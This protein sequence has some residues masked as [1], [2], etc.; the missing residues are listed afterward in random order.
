[1]TDPIRPKLTIPIKMALGLGWPPEVIVLIAFEL[2]VLFFYTQVLGL[3]GTLTGAALFVAM[4]LDGL[5]DPILGTLS[6]NLRKAPWGR[7][8]TLMFLAPIPM[9]LFFAL[10]F[11]P[12]AFLHGLGLFVWLT[13]TVVACRVSTALFIIPNSAQI[14]EMSRESDVRASLSIYR[15]V[16]QTVFQ[17]ALL[18]LSFKVFFAPSAHFANGQE[19]R[20]NYPLFGMAWGAVLFVI[21]ALSAAGTYRFM[22]AVEDSTPME[23]AKPMSAARFLRSWKVALT[24]NPNVRVVFLGAV[25]MVA[26]SGIARTL[27]SHMAI[28]F[29]E[30]TPGQIAN[31]QLVTIPGMLVGLFLA[32]YLLKFSDMKPLILVSMAAIY[33]SYIL[34]A[35]LKLMGLFPANAP[36]LVD[37]TLLAANLVQGLGFGVIGIVSALM[38]AQTADEEELL[39]GGPEQGLLFG[40]I[41]LGTKLGSGLGKLLSGMALDMIKFPVGKPRAAIGQAVID[42]LALTQIVWVVVLG[43]LSLILWG[44][45]SITNRR[46]AEIKD[47]LALRAAARLAESAAPAQ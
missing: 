28:Y 40:F 24:G 47:A 11:M 34:P 30:L 27:T 15:S 18:W 1:M 5:A 41:F 35:A 43:G 2:F 31:W 13:V 20:A 32:R 23:Q 17:L 33:L 45:Y 37:D 22:R 42:N 9:G 16:A 38:C 19:D 44:G 39:L 12:P 3:S 6:D 25:T 46:H 4:C 26:A 36:A 14:A 10:V 29:W 8:H 7:R 21:T